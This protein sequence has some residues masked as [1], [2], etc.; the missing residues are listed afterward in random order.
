VEGDGESPPG[1]HQSRD[2]G[3]LGGVYHRGRVVLGEHT[4]DRHHIGTMVHEPPFQ[5]RLDLQQPMR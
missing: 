3:G 2:T 1:S 5:P 4:F